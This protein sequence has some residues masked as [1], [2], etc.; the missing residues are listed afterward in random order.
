MRKQPLSLH[1]SSTPVQRINE[2]SPS[3]DRKQGRIHDFKLGGGAHLKKLRRAEG[4][5]KIF[6]VFYAKKIIFFSNFRGR[7]WE[8][9]RLKLYQLEIQ[10]LR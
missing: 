5:A 7:T 2:I 10:A 4:G 1:E 9:Y 3:P 8:G 6:G